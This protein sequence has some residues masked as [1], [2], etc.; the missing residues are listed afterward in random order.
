MLDLEESGTAKSNL[1]IFEL[2]NKVNASGMDGT[3]TSIIFNQWYYDASTPA[4]ADLARLSAGT[5][6]DWT[7]TASTQDG[8]LAF[9]R[10]HY[11]PADI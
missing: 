4:V 8:Y 1:D 6:S 7:S 9:E 5:E 11:K 3:E 10:D 2:T